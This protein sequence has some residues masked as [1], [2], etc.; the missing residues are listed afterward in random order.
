MG[1]GWLLR[2]IFSLG[3]KGRSRDAGCEQAGVACNVAVPPPPVPVPAIVPLRTCDQSS[4]P[5]LNSQSVE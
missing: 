5:S 4:V 3:Q 1:R 2:P